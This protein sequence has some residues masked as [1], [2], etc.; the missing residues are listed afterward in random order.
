MSRVLYIILIFYGQIV[1][2]TVNFQK[3]KNSHSHELLFNWDILE[4]STWTC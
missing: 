2:V 3:G 1:L 4:K